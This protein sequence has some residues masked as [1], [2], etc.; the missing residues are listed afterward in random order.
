MSGHWPT[1]RLFGMRV[2]MGNDV[3]E[4]ESIAPF[5]QSDARWALAIAKSATNSRRTYAQQFGVVIFTE[6]AIEGTEFGSARPRSK[7][8]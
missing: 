6:H 2:E 1:S 7:G 5:A 4:P 3:A 8:T